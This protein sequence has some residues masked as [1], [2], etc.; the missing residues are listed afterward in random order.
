[1]KKLL[2]WLVENATESEPPKKQDCKTDI[3]K[4]NLPSLASDTNSPSVAS[5][6]KTASDQENK[7]LLPSE[8]AA[9]FDKDLDSKPY[10]ESSVDATQLDSASVSCEAI[11]DTK[12]EC[13]DFDPNAEDFTSNLEMAADI[14]FPEILNERW[15]GDKRTLLHI[16]AQAGQ[17]EI[18]YLLLEAGADPA[19]W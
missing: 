4:K 5:L 9:D 19:L 8:K 3:F 16:V 15:G 7:G 14:K 2:S 10:T 6:V 1:M 11:K 17:L 18:L 13:L 12:D